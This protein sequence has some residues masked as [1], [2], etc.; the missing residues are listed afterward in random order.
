MQAQTPEVSSAEASTTAELRC[1]SVEQL[2]KIHRD[3]DAC[4]KVIWLAGGFDPA[5]VADAQ[6]R[7]KE[8]E[9]LLSAQAE[10]GWTQKKPTQPGAYWIRG[11]LLQADALV[12]VA[13]ADGVLWCNLHGINSEPRFGF[14]IRQL[15]DD[16]EWLGPL[17]PMGSL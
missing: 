9:A 3:L 5:Y 7:L 17:A 16:F 10:R 14:T 2:Q 12:E 1:V 13:Q 15:S 8:I 11:S 4:Q 6:E